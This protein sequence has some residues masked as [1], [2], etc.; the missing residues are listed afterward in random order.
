MGVSKIRVPQNGWFILENPIKKG[1]IGGYHY[2]R[3]HP[4]LSD[5]LWWSKFPGSRF[6]TTAKKSPGPGFDCWRPSWFVGDGFGGFGPLKGGRTGWLG[7]GVSEAYWGCI[8]EYI[9]DMSDDFFL[10]HHYCFFVSCLFLFWN[11]LADYDAMSHPI[12]FFCTN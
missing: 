8:Q 6:F 5:G 12:D 2:F 11:L 9:Y 3:K 4:Y 10:V 7:S 1:M